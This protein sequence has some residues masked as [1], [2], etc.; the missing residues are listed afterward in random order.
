MFTVDNLLFLTIRPELI[1][2]YEKV[3]RP[4]TYNEKGYSLVVKRQGAWLKIM[5]HNSDGI[6]L[7][8]Y[9]F[10][11]ENTRDMEDVIRLGEAIK[12]SDV[13]FLLANYPSLKTK[14]FGQIYIEII[15]RNFKPS[16]V[17]GSQTYP[18]SEYPTLN[19]FMNKWIDENPQSDPNA[20]FG[21]VPISL[22][23][24]LEKEK[25]ECEISDQFA[26]SRN[27]I[28]LTFLPNKKLLKLAISG[29]LGEVYFCD[30]DLVKVQLIKKLIDQEEYDNLLEMENLEFSSGSIN[31]VSEE[32]VHEHFHL[33]LKLSPDLDQKGFWILP[34]TIYSRDYRTLELNRSPL[35][36]KA[37]NKKDAIT[38][39]KSGELM[40][41]DIIDFQLIKWSNIQK[42]IENNKKF[43]ISEGIA[44]ID[45]NPEGTLQLEFNIHVGGF[46]KWEIAINEAFDKS[47]ANAF[48]ELKN[49]YFNITKSDYEEIDTSVYHTEYEPW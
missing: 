1:S 16:W 18:I 4:R 20:H 27:N 19:T 23:S 17:I 12:H 2:T 46:N 47:I 9:E 44:S 36:I 26:H 3:K 13:T 6:K 41:D 48:S 7:P 40:S 21:K 37:S 43:S 33:A 38:L 29:Q 11:V 28:K 34:K 49:G 24:L 8:S 35:K 5:K 10:P 39:I 31:L 22:V 42:A 45:Y 30:V 15:E 32:Q 25:Y 14:I